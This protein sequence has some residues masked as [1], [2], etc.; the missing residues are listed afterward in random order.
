MKG[1]VALRLD[2]YISKFAELQF[3]YRAVGREFHKKGLVH[4]NWNHILRN[5][6][7]GIMIGES[8]NTNMKILLASIILHD[9]GRL[10]RESDQ[11]HHSVGAEIAPKY[12]RE[13]GF[14]NEEIEAVKHCIRSHGQRGI[15]EPRSQEAKVCYDVDVLSCSVGYLGVARVFDYFMR[16]ENMGVREML[17]IPSGRKGPRRNFY[18]K[19]GKML[20]E[21]GFLKA[22]RFWKELESEITRE[23][24]S[25]RRVIP[26]YEGD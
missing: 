24:Q 14:T 21:K 16:E 18:T 20:G 3:L 4:H 8:E 7:A 10:H 19:T 12:L 26:E 5:L 6:A 25:V 11:D 15:E 13:A 22:S 2:Y 9:I 23:M 17:N 1:V